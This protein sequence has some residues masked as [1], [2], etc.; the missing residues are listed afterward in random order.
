MF[1]IDEVTNYMLG[2]AIKNVQSD[3]TFNS[4]KARTTQ[5]VVYKEGDIDL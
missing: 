4:Y 5:F 2:F 1:G 3:V